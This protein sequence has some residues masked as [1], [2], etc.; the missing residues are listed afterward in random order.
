MPTRALRIRRRSSSPILQL[1]GQAGDVSDEHELTFALQVDARRPAARRAI[2][3]MGGGDLA[4]LA[5]LAGEL[6]Q[7]IELLDQAA[8]IPTGVLTRRGLAAQIRDAYD[9]WGRRSRQRELDRSPLRQTGVAPHTAGPVAREEHWSHLACDGALHCTLW[10]AEWP[11]IDVRAL[12]LQP[13]L[14]ASQTTRTVAMCMEL[15]GPSRAIRQAERAATE[16]ADR[17]EP[18]RPRRAAHEPAPVTARPGR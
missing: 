1:I 6:G 7:L 3:R 8:I 12:F 5:V 9:P 14:L 18:P 15:L 11:R 4:A 13:L 17:A 16:T 10:A 2:A